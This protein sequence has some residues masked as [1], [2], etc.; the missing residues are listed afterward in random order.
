[1]TGPVYFDF[2]EVFDAEEYLYFYEGTLRDED[3]LAQ[4]AFIERELAL[5]PGAQIVDLGCGHGRHANELARR[6]HR[7]LGVDLVPGFLEVARAEASQHDGLTVEYALGDV[8][9]LVASGASFDHALCLFDAFGFLED[10]GNEAF[11][12]GAHAALHPGGSL[13]L[14]VRSRDWVV[15]N[16]LPVTVLDKGEDL[17]V[18]RHM[19]DVATGRLVDRRT[20]VRGGRARTVT[21]SIRLYTLS[22]LTA[23]LRAVGFAVERTWGGWDGAP[24][25]LARNRMLLLA[26]RA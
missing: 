15:K 6:G 8:R 18:D 12:R 11:L 20:Y 21:F 3:T 4:V 19:F 13:L 10:D 5:E 7:V 25:H 9:Q 23:L 16:I 26:R 22:E 24:V 2:A 1:M 14:D 17:M